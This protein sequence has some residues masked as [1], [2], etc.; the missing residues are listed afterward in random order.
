MNP[1]CEICFDSF[2]NSDRLPITIMQCGHTYCLVCIDELTKYD[3]RC[4]KDRELI[5]NQKPNYALLDVL[6]SIIVQQS[7]SESE[8]VSNFL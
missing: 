3:F 1:K 7:S 4:P 8:N 5:T 2:N 6:N